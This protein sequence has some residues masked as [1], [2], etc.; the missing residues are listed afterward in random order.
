MVQIAGRYQLVENVK[1]YEFLKKIGSTDEQAS[2]A[3]KAKPF[4]TVGIDGDK[5]T[6]KIEG[7]G[8]DLENH[9]VLGKQCEEK[10]AD[11]SVSKTTVTKEGDALKLVS[12]EEGGVNLT[13]IYKFTDSGFELSMNLGGIEAKQIYK[14]L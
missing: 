7:F 13:R 6:I 2:A 9:F 3:D 11:G 8:D 14:R 1:F 12:I 4:V 10:Q 5:V